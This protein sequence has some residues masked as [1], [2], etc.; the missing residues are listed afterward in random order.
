[1]IGDRHLDWDGC[2]NVRDLGGLG[3]ADG[4][5]TR[6]G[7]VVRSDTPDRLTA[8]G[9]SALHAY[10]IRTLVD[11]RNDSEVRAWNGYRPPGITILRT[12][13][14]DDADTRF[15]ERWRHLY[16]TPLYYRTFLDHKPDRCA[17]A[18]EAIAQAPPGG[19]LFHCVA[20]RDRTG[21]LAFL[22]L[23]LAGVAPDD[24]ASD[25]ELTA[26][27]LRPLYAK[28]G[29]EDEAPMIRRRLE[30]ENTSA[31][32][33]ILSTLAE[34]DVEAYLLAGGLGKED[35]RTARTR[36]LGPAA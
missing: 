29:Q 7:A 22:L 28:L 33:I 30:R 23:G 13:L 36:L 2:Y 12:P 25:Y 4:R 14:D 6:R 19:V 32:E 35:L 15:W 27:R 5:Q 26:E 3:T 18:V 24:I 21:M 11:L 1:M 10:G 9:W 31:R 34:T 8:A 17:A 16:G 20:G